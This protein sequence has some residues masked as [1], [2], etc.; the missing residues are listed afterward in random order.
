MEFLTSRFLPTSR[1][2]LI[3][4]DGARGRRVKAPAAYEPVVPSACS[5][6]IRLISLDALGA[7][8]N[9]RAVHRCELFGPLVGCA[10]GEPLSALHILRLVSSP[11]GLFKSAPSR[12]LRLLLLNKADAVPRALAEE[13]ARSIITAGACDAVYVG[14]T[15]RGAPT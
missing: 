6:V 14:A 10:P 3:E 9:A 15:G 4:A 11:A 8:M 1:V 7:P 5:A 13:C 12:A 2:I